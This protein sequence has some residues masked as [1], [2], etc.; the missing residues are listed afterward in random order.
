MI[1]FVYQ[2]EIIVSTKKSVRFVRVEA[3]C[4]KH[5]VEYKEEYSIREAVVVLEKSPMWIG[6]MTKPG[7]ARYRFFG[8]RLE[9]YAVAS[10]GKELVR[11]LIPVSDLEDYLIDAEVEKE[12]EIQRHADPAGYYNR[13]RKAKKLTVREQLDRLSTEE[14]MALIA[15][16][17]STADV[18]VDES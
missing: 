3:Q 10:T 1:K 5:G 13:S 18:S 11:W 4:V 12:R 16:L 15:E 7:T 2:K 6:R 9:V 17:M 14:R 8:S